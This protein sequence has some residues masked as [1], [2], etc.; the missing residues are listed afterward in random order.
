MPND[1]FKLFKFGLVPL[2]VVA[3]WS[4]S[5]LPCGL[6]G[7]VD[8]VVVDFEVEDSAAVTLELYSGGNLDTIVTCGFNSPDSSECTD[9]F[10]AHSLPDKARITAVRAGNTY[11]EEYLIPYN[12]VRPNGENCSPECI[13]GKVLIH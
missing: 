2:A 4:C 13:Q 7:C 9:F 1:M 6:I 11:T 8:G 5:F 10:Y 12:S 3:L